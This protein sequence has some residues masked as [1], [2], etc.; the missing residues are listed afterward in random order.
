[1][2]VFAAIFVLVLHF[3][4]V[5]SLKMSTRPSKD[6]VC[7]VIGDYSTFLSTSIETLADAYGLNIVEDRENF[8]EI[9]HICYRVSSLSLY[10]QK[11]NEL[12]KFGVKLI[13]SIIG[14]RPI[15]IFR[16]HEPICYLRFQISLI[17]L[18][19]PKPGSPYNDGLEH[20]EIVVAGNEKLSI[21]EMKEKEYLEHWSYSKFPRVNFDAKALS[22]GLNCD[23][24]ISLNE[25][26]SCKF[27]CFPLNEIIA[28][29]K[30]HNLTELIS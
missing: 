9:D 12:E 16:L 2:I 3:L 10:E 23:L 4:V 5:R 27:H 29:E 14:H 30:D 8:V 24:A 13:E 20:L 15:S 19:S 28:Y 26:T 21:S 1:M 7:S 11:K 17:E 25:N 6:N 18:P 22:K